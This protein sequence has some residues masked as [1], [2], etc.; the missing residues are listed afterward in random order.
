MLLLNDGDEGPT[1][2]SV[3]CI[4]N[5]ISSGEPGSS[6]GS[7][8]NGSLLTMPSDGTTSISFESVGEGSRKSQ[9]RIVSSCEL[10]TIWKSSNCSRKTR[11][12][13]SWDGKKMEIIM[14]YNQG[15]ETASH[16]YRTLSDKSSEFLVN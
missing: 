8:C 2:A 9:M 7:F 6:L 15:V 5:W 10:L 11:P 1:C 14:C 12:V 4:G 3:S 16:S 13:C